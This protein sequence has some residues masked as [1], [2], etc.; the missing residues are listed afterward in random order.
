MTPSQKFFER[1]RSMETDHYRFLAAAVGNGN[2]PVPTLHVAE[3]SLKAGY[4]PVELL[5]RLM[6]HYSRRH[7][8]A[9]VRSA[10]IVNNYQIYRNG[11]MYRRG[12]QPEYEI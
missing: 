9:R 10:L 8:G 3:F 12:P 1:Q 5:A 6:K 11:L 7:S 2:R 4:D